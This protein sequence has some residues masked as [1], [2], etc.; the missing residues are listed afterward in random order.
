MTALLMLA[1]RYLRARKL[2]TALTT[3][4]IVFGVAVI[5]AG[6]LLLPSMVEALRR[7]TLA[8]AGTVDLMISAV[9]GATFAP[10]PALERARAVEGVAAVSGVLQQAVTIPL[11]EGGPGFQR[12][13]VGVDPQTITDVRTINLAE[14]RWFAPGERGVVILPT[15]PSDPQGASAPIGSTI[16]LPTTQGLRSF[17][18]VGR[19]AP[20]AVPSPEILMPLADAQEL[21]GAP[22]Q[23]STIEV[24]LR[25]GVDRQAVAQALLAALGEGFELGATSSLDAVGT[26]DVSY[27]MFNLL[28]ALSLFIG[29]FIIFNTFRTAVIERRHDLG[30]LRTIGA[31]RR[32]VTRLLLLES[33]LQGLLGTAIGLLAG[34]GLA[35]LAVLAFNPIVHQYFAGVRFRLE[36]SWSALLTAGLA[37]VLT[38]LI[39][40]YLPARAAG[41]V[42]PLAALRPVS[43]EEARRAA[44]WSVVAGGL[45]VVVGIALLLVGPQGAAGGA[46]LVLVG[47]AIA[48]PALILPITRLVRP[49]LVAVWAGE[50]EIAQ[51][52][53]L[54]Q[55]SRAAVTGSTLMVGLAVIVMVGS[56]IGSLRAYTIGLI[57][58]TLSSDVLLLPQNIGVLT[59]N[60][61]ADPRLAEEL[62]QLPQVAAVASLRSVATKI[63]D[64]T[65]NVLG[66]DPEI[67]PRVATL[68]FEAGDERSAY[69]ALRQGQNAIVNPLLATTLGLQ[70]GDQITLQTPHG[71]RSYTVVGIG[72]DVL[73]FKVNTV[74]VSQ[75]HLARDFAQTR[76]VL[77]MLKLRPGVEV[78]AALPAIQAV[79]ARYPQFTVYNTAAFRQ[80]FVDQTNRLLNVVFWPICAVILVP[81]ALGLLNTL[82]MNV[83]E[84]TRE[85]GMLRA[86]GATRRQVRR[87]VL[88]EAALVGIF[89]A[90]T[91]MLAGLVLSYGFVQALSLGFGTPFPYAV[92]LWGLLGALLAALLLTLLVSALPARRA[93]RLNMIEALRYE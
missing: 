55:P 45:F 68:D 28:G 52:N 12:I 91:G 82:T 1:S 22:G 44:R 11:A 72:S 37:G 92:P 16:T 8:A 67:Y 17:K 4:S 5:F 10:H 57:T 88:A 29:A 90:L 79:A 49:L 78:E 87:I 42:S 23:I 62:R 71:S 48:S 83:L 31:T 39:A 21:L 65:V 36:W 43:T 86:I 26:L 51:G 76:D 60:L 38:A 7:N 40:G 47:L 64:Q 32:Q 63:G 41:R 85:I 54:R 58:K 13:I 81:A 66:I 19:L 84:R 74:F 73:N 56:V 14:G 24:A 35:A 53:L 77:L 61:G 18:V 89:G 2:R 20:S 15:D 25:P 6:N 69:A 30:V 50:G 27:T 75:E 59:S 33:L 34:L 3:L 70:L 9:G 80:Q 93:A 46:L